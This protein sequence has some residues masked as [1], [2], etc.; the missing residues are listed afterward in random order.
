MISDT[1]YTEW[2]ILFMTYLTW[3]C[4]LWH[5]VQMDVEH[6]YWYIQGRASS[7]YGTH[8]A[9]WPILFHH[10][11]PDSNLKQTDVK[12]RSVE[13]IPFLIFLNIFTSCKIGCSHFKH[14][15]ARHLLSAACNY[16]SFAK[17]VHYFCLM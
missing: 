9:T 1:L 15:C 11:R 8:R 2:P 12:T 6:W 16:F 7:S 13:M 3:S 10:R 4:Y 14:K 5:K 17:T